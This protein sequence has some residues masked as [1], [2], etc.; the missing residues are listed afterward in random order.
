MANSNWAEELRR[1]RRRSE[2]LQRQLAKAVAE[3]ADLERRLEE[4]RV[5]R[6]QAEEACRRNRP[7]LGSPERPQR[8]EL[9]VIYH[10]LPVG[11]CTVDSELR[12]LL[13][14]QRLADISG[15]PVEAHPGRH[16]RDL[17]PSLAF[18]LEPSIQQ[19]L[20]TSEPMLDVELIGADP[21]DLAAQR[22]WLISHHP[23]KRD[24]W[25][26]GVCTVVQDITTQKHAEE[27]LRQSQRLQ[28]EAEKLA[29]TGRMAARI[30]HE[31][32]NPLAGIKNSFL[33]VKKA[34]PTDHPRYEFVGLIEK[35]I[36]RIAE[37]VR[38][39]YDL[40]RPNQDGAKEVFV[41]DMVQDVVTML[42]PL[43]KRHKV[44][45]GIEMSE[46]QLVVCLPEGSLR[47]VLYNL[48][49]NAIEASPYGG[50]VK[51]AVRR[52]EETLC[53]SVADQGD[54]IPCE[55]QSRVFEPFFTTKERDTLGGLGLGLPI[56]KGIVE[57]L[58]GSIC[59]QSQTGQGS[60]F[61][62]KLPLHQRSSDPERQ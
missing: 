9:E 53:V 58:R 50:L 41:A 48:L 54:G 49:S 8:A 11:L 19:V 22:T 62:V 43:C 30:A 39:M 34:V 7:W 5:R 17:I 32:N 44:L 10:N 59:F 25:L 24:D 51:I 3:Q 15:I 16:I 20:D 60:V 36:N 31:I 38:Q 61:C 4:E 1:E 6:Q 13:V 28:A 21:K 57:A 27:A 23:L 47:Q 37:I 40:H 29:A 18:H 26:I 33:L 2:E 35:E 56:C 46:P 14:N 45:I 55:Q 52:T 12:C 42:Q